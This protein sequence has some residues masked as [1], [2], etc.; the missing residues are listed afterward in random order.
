M[1]RFLVAAVIVVLL[2]YNPIE[3]S[4]KGHST[5]THK[6]PGYTNRYVNQEGHYVP[7]YFHKQKSKKSSDSSD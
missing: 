7:R 2:T 6:T 5:H 4:A 1:G 3:A